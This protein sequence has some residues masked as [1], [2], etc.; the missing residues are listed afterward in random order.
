MLV[1]GS[2]LARSGHR[3]API[4][5]VD[6]KL[7]HR[8]PADPALRR[9]ERVILTAPGFARRANVVVALVGHRHLAT[10]AASRKGVAVYVFALPHW[11]GRGRY[12][13]IFSG[14]PRSYQRGRSSRGRPV[15]RRD[16]AVLQVRVPY[17][18]T[19]RFRVVVGRIPRSHGVA[20]VPAPRGETSEQDP[21]Q[22]GADV[23]VLLVL[24]A[25]LLLTGVLLVITGRMR[26]RCAMLG[27]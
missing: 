11:L 5:A 16:P 4:T 18:P 8:L 25:A 22:T 23:V 20:R 14:P 26:R 7:G 12:E 27:P 2:A 3:P 17:D 6:P 1:A 9:G 13:L 24:G 21:A 19:W 15:P 10:I